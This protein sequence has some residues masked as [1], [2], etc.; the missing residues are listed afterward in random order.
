MGPASRAGRLQGGSSSFDMANT[1]TLTLMESRITTL[2]KEE[3]TVVVW[4]TGALEVVNTFLQ[5]ARLSKFFRH[6]YVSPRLRRSLILVLVEACYSGIQRGT[7]CSTRTACT[8]VQLVAV[9]VRYVF[10]LGRMIVTTIYPLCSRELV[11]G[12]LART[13]S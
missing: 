6:I 9:G 3:Q 13:R 11:A 4:Y 7:L 12:A 2:C 5:G 10:C 8:F 1:I